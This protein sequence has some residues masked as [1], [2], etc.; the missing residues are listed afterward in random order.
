MLTAPKAFMVMLAPT[1]FSPDELLKRS[2]TV[3][4]PAREVRMMEPPAATLWASGLPRASLAGTPEAFTVPRVM[5]PE[6]VA[7]T[8]PAAV[9]NPVAVV[10]IPAACISF[11]EYR[12]TVPPLAPRTPEELIKVFPVITLPAAA[13]DTSPALPTEPK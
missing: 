3:M 13:R 7:T 12:L 4:A 11:R 1:T 8:L 10:L 9:N 2:L 5:F 6:A